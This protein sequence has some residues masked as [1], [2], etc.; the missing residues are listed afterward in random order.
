MT[1]T[2]MAPTVEIKIWAV[3]DGVGDV[4]Q[5]GRQRQQFVA[6]ERAADEGA[7]MPTRSCG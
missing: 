4:R 6:H 5:A 2:M 1:T 7:E 3:G